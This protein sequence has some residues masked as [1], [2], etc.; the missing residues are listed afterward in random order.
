VSGEDSRVFLLDRFGAPEVMRMTHRRTPAPDPGEVLVEVEVSGVNFAD[1]M[2]RRGEYLRDQPLSMAPGSEVVGHVVASGAEATIPTGTRVAGWIEAGGAYADHVLVPAHRAYPVPEDLPAGAIAAVFLQGTT[3]EFGLHR[4]GHVRPGET[5]LVHAAAG[6]VGGLAVQ[7]A[8]IAGVHV[9]ATASSAAKL[10][11]ARAH[12]SD[13]LLDSSDPETLTARLL[14]ASGGRGCDVILDGV[15]GPLFKPSL[16]AL[17]FGGR[18]VI[19]GAA[20]QEPSTLDARHL[21]V[22]GQTICGY[23]LARLIEEDPDEPA[24]T[25]AHLCG[26]LRES[27]LH[28]RYELLALERAVEAHHRIE[29]RGLTGK[30]VLG[31]AHANGAAL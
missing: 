25:L 13:V 15:G 17:A 1:T 3:A 12:G 9:I 29:A 7:L 28:P 8:K 14:E 6:G 10:E 23:L 20:S 22:R 5:V 11:V 30:L 21:L 18:Y 31:A 2:I 27:R 26:L 4:Y 16:R 19:L 24:R